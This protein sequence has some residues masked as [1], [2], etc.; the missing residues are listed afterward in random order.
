MIINNFTP[1]R[2]NINSPS[3]NRGNLKRNEIDT[4]TFRGGT[5][6]ET[7][8]LQRAKSVLIEIFEATAAAAKLK[9]PRRHIFDLEF[10]QRV[11]EGKL[12]AE[13]VYRNLLHSYY[14]RM[15]FACYPEDARFD[16]EIYKATSQETP[17]METHNSNQWDYRYPRNRRKFGWSTSDKN[18]DR[19]SVNAVTDRT[20]IGRLDTLFGQG[21]I[22][23]YYKTPDFP[24][25]WLFRHDPVTIYLHEP[26]TP[27][28]LGDIAELARPFIRS[29][30]DVLPGYKF[31]P[32]LA[33]ERSPQTE[34]LEQL[35]MRAKCIDPEI[36]KM[37]RNRFTTDEQRLAT[38]SGYYAAAKKLLD[39]IYTNK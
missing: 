16:P 19:I 12:P 28:V 15:R 39:A 11:R 1:I 30:K 32:G 29:T 23:G 26:A 3:I 25:A 9:N 37:L 27:R 14:E 17:L 33:L 22:K 31:A 2:R 6:S 10:A 34:E 7:Q 20:F 4:V 36:E 18:T 24:Y 38:S 35:L 5:T 21:Y 13:D 8:A